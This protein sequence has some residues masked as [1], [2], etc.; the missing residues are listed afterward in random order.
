MSQNIYDRIVE[1]Y[2]MGEFDAAECRKRLQYI[3]SQD[4]NASASANYR[5]ASLDVD[6]LAQEMNP[7]G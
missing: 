3:Y 5:A 7:N 1:R 2:E 4:D 6:F